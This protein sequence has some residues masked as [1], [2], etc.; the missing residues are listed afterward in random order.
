M[1]FGQWG[2]HLLSPSASST[3]TAAERTE[4]SADFDPS[5]VVIGEFLG[6]SDLLV[7]APSEDGERRCLVAM[8]LDSREDWFAVGPTIAN[9]LAKLIQEGGQKYWE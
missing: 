5:D 2:L 8:P 3:R 1:Q 4:R 9:F 7:F 6:D